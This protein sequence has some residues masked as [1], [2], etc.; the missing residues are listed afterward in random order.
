MAKMR[1]PKFKIQS[2]SLMEM[3]GYTIPLKIMSTPLTWRRQL[4]RAMEGSCALFLTNN[5]KPNTPGEYG[6]KIFTC[7]ETS[8]WEAI[9]SWMRQS[10]AADQGLAPPVG[11]VVR[12]NPPGRMPVWGYETCIAD[13]GQE[14][15]DMFAEETKNAKSK[16]DGPVYLERKLRRV[17]LK[18]SFVN[19]LCQKMPAPNNG[20]GYWFEDCPAMIAPKNTRL[21][22]GGDL[23]DGNCGLWQGNLVCIDFG[24]HSATITGKRDCLAYYNYD[25][26]KDCRSIRKS[27]RKAVAA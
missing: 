21:R 23:H 4:Q 2:R 22:L 1:Y 25:Y 19:D 12:F 11:S 13:M 16:Y 15:F 8:M 17:N 5:A 10:I 26:D 6:I 3:G 18:G 20:G 7:G 27:N 9:C 24:Y 14:Y